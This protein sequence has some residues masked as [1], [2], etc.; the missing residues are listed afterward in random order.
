MLK[1]QELG[2]QHNGSLKLPQSEGRLQRSAVDWFSGIEHTD[3]IFFSG[4]QKAGKLSTSKKK[5][6]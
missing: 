1:N 2:S 4:K 3:E 5:N 6:M